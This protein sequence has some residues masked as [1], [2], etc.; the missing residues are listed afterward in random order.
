M[1]AP[2]HTLRKSENPCIEGGIQPCM[3]IHMVGQ[4][5]HP[6]QSQGIKDQPQGHELRQGCKI[7]C[8]IRIILFQD[9]TFRIDKDTG[10]QGEATSLS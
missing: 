3:P 4:S 8:N 1:T 9:T 7:P 6:V 10:Y 2:D 5:D